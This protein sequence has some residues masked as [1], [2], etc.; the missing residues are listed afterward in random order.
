VADEAISRGI[1]IGLKDAGAIAH[2]V[3]QCGKVHWSVEEQFGR[4]NCLVWM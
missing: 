3:I 4:R 2:I 1:S